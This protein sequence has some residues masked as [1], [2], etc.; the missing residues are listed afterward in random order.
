[1]TTDTMRQKFEKEITRPIY[2]LGSY[3]SDR[4]ISLMWEMFQIGIKQG[5]RDLIE[6]IGEPVAH[7]FPS[8][9]KKFEFGEHVDEAYSIEMGSPAERSVPLYRLPEDTPK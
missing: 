3:P 7:I 8:T 6:A 1:M 2:G 4:E 5:Q 9:L